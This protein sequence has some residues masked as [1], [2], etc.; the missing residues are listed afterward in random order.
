MFKSDTYTPVCIK[1]YLRALR[2]IFPF[3]GK[4]E[5]LYLKQLKKQLIEFYDEFPLCT[6]ENITDQFG[7]PTIVVANYCSNMADN[8]LIHRLQY[9]KYLHYFFSLLLLVLLSLSLFRTILIDKAIEYDQSIQMKK[10]P[11]NYIEND[12]Q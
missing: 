4:Q 6:Y 3:Q 11:T 1:E 12:Q 2:T 8:K 7:A 5:R 9:R 10:L